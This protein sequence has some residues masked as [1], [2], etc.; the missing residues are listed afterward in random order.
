MAVGPLG[1]LNRSKL[2]S[3]AGQLKY[4]KGMTHV[5]REAWESMSRD[6]IVS[7]ILD[8]MELGVQRGDGEG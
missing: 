7:R 5:T 4:P 8:L 2:L 3:V 6:A 1:Q